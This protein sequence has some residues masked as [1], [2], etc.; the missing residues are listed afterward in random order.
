VVLDERKFESLSRKLNRLT[1]V[2]MFIIL[3]NMDTSDLSTVE[4]LSTRVPQFLKN[5]LQN[6]VDIPIF[7]VNEVAEIVK[8]L[9]AQTSAA[10]LHSL[11]LVGGKSTRMGRDKAQITYHG[12]PQWAHMAEILRGGDENET[13]QLYI[14]C[15]NEQQENFNGVNLIVDNFTDL[16]PYGAILSAFRENP[17][18][19]WLVV[20]CDLPLMDKQTL[21]FLIAHRDPSKIATTFKS[22]ESAEGFPE[23]LITIWE[24]KSY[25]V[26]LQYLAQGISCPRKVLI[27]SDVMILDAPNP[28][29]LMNVNT[30]QDYEKVV[31]FNIPLKVL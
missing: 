17:N 22:P 1:Q 11:I 8:F 15:R 3:D 4:K 28:T 20:A 12:K 31:S 2:D 14:S 24:P 19:A 18:V 13:A 27:N 9:I 10:P 26:L 5:H 7:R 29:A 23:P 6:W 16:G 21:D 25:Q 30:P